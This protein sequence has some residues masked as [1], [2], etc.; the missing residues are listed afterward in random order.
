MILI[1]RVVGEGYNHT[2]W[3]LLFCPRVSQ[4]RCEEGIDYFQIMIIKEIKRKLR[5]KTHHSPTRGLSAGVSLHPL[6]LK[7]ENAYKHDKE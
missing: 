7:E 2:S 5:K 6:K 3:I 1:A 4:L